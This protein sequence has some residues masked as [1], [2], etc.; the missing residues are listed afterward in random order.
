M[1]L[2]KEQLEKASTMPLDEL[3]ALAIQEAEAGEAA[4][5]PPIAKP[6][7]KQEEILDNSAESAEGEQQEEEPTVYRKEIDL[8]DGSGVEIFE[9]E[10][11]EALVDKLADA[12]LN[13]TK[14]IRELSQKIKVE[15]VRTAQQKADDEYRIAEQL[16]T[17]PKKAVREIIAEVIA[18]RE[19]ATR[20]SVE[21]QSRF[22]QRHSDFIPNEHN[23]R[24]MQL[25]AQR[26]GYTEFSVESLE[27]AYQSLKARG[28]LKLKAEGSEEAT[29]AEKAETERIAQAK[30][31]AAQPRSLKKGSTF[32]G[33]R[34]SAT[35]PAKTAPSEDELY[36]PDKWPL[37]KLKEF[38]NQQL[39]EQQAQ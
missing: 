26:L 30:L 27:K 7:P 38:A 14:K 21:A 19:A 32:T 36:D 20:E 11:V 16:K 15:N 3:R 1:E 33:T 31:E 35:P 2:T 13:A 25:E 37:E 23:G 24:E 4:E 18:E 17:E 39:R 34:T 29:E 6:A 8:G 10:S 9:A 5:T 28:I 22:V 12:K